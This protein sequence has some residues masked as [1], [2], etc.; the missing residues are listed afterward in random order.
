MTLIS[1][2]LEELCKRQREYVNFFFDN[3]DLDVVKEN[4]NL[5][6]QCKGVIFFSGVGKSGFVAQKLATTMTSTGTKA[7]FLAP[8]DALHGDLGMLGPDDLFVVISKSGETD[9]LFNLLPF[10]RNKGTK[11]ISW[12]SNPN[13][14]L[15]KAASLMVHLPLRREL[16]P[17][18]LAPMTSAGIQMIFGDILAAEIMEL[19][20]F[21][22]TE[23]AKNHPAGRIGKRIICKVK[24]LMLVGN[25]L[26]VCSAEEKLL[27]VVVELSDKR[28]GCL[29]I[30]DKE[31]YLL[32]IFTDGDLGRS[33]KNHGPEVLHT[34][35]SDLMITT[36]KTIE[37]EK[38]AWDAM[39]LM[40]S[41]AK[42]EITVL[43]VVDS[44]KVVG[45][46]KMHDI[47]QSG[48]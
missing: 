31:N 29:L 48:I 6:L 7:M 28:C 9:E 23:Y 14:R 21:S 22:L 8:T 38:L 47:L 17:F 18:D 44:G 10:V 25:N 45:L 34:K 37:S 30:T 19:R 4:V 16:C 42:K 33:L 41:H 5:F 13:S 46:I 2:K 20:G 40:E 3:L 27:N 12:V 15:G 1:S 36:P 43:P 26:P 39:K 11:I 35:I 24:D 32:G